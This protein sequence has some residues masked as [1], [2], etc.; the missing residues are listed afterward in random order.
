[1]QL[2]VKIEALTTRINDAR[3]LR[4]RGESQEARGRI[5]DAIKSYRQSLELV[6]DKS[7]EAHVTVLEERLAS[8][9]CSFD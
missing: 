1:M 6:L 4:A 3:S 5:D 2:Q 9:G 7:L 8:Q